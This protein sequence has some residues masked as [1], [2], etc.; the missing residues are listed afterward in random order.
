MN[1]DLRI[2]YKLIRD[3]NER[4]QNKNDIL[5][6]IKKRKKD[7][8]NFIIPQSKYADLIFHLNPH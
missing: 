8:E 2:H 6:I 1:E 4:K 5:K 3:E 7:A